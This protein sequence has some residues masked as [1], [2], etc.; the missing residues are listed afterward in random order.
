MCWIDVYLGPPDVIV[1]D[2]AKNVLE[3]VY[4]AITDMLHIHTRSV[5]VESANSISIVEQYHT[6]IQRAHNIIT[7]ESPDFGKDEVLQMAVKAIYDSVEPD[8]LVPTLLVLVALHS[9][10]FPSDNPTSS[11]F[12]RAAAL[13]KAFIAMSKN[14]AS[15]QA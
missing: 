1:H 15:R 3:A 5:P 13:E 9:L 8:G 14:F 4:Q 2:T 6:P 7:K 10:G 11:T 12:K